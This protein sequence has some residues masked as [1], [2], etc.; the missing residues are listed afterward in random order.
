MVELNDCYLERCC[1]DLTLGRQLPSTLRFWCWILSR[2]F[3]KK[4]S[5]KQRE[6]ANCLLYKARG[7]EGSPGMT[8]FSDTPGANAYQIA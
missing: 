6:R 2:I 8:G 1:S 5:E 4:G 7:I 3:L